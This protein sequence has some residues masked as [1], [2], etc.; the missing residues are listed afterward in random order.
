LC[1]RDKKVIKRISN[2]M[3]LKEI[4]LIKVFGKFTIKVYRRGLEDG[5]N[6]SYKKCY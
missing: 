3:S 1:S 6:W 2:G 4:I 5:F